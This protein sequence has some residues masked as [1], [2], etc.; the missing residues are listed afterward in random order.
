M[1]AKRASGSPF[2]LPQR[3][4][5]TITQLHTC[6]ISVIGDQSVNMRPCSSM[7]Q[8]WVSEVFALNVYSHHPTGPA[9]SGLCEEPMHKFC[10][11][12]DLKVFD[13][14]PSLLGVSCNKEMYLLLLRFGLS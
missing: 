13:A 10:G 11:V 5:D 8:I 14:Q 1:V 3:G 9:V 4:G 6:C 2:I 12:L 7:S